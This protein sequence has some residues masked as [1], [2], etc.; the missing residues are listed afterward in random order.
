[1]SGAGAAV[2]R[3]AFLSRRLGLRRQFLAFLLDGL[4]LRLTAFSAGQQACLLTWR[5]TTPRLPGNH[6]IIF[7]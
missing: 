1:M 2:R 3:L 6:P 4:S 7:R 5:F